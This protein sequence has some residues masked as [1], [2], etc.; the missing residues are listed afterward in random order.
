MTFSRSTLFA[1]LAACA[2][3]ASTA[4]AGDPPLSAPQKQGLK[5]AED[6]LKRGKDML[7]KANS[8]AAVDQAV[9]K[10]ENAV[11][12]LKS[13]D[14]PA[15]HSRAKEIVGECE[16]LTAA[17]ATK[18]AE[19]TK[20]AADAAVAA[21][22]K[23]YPDLAA[24]DEWYQGIRRQYAF[25]RFHDLHEQAAK[26][27]KEFQDVA[28]RH[29]ELGEKYKGFFASNNQIA[30]NVKGHAGL[31]EKELRQFFQ[32]AQNAVTKAAGDIK[33]N[34][35]R[36]EEMS[37][38]AVAEKKPAFFTGGVRQAMETSKNAVAVLKALVGEKHEK[39]LA[40][41]KDVAAA[42]AQVDTAYAALKEDVIAAQQMPED[43]YKGDDKAK[44]EQ[45]IR[46]AWAKEH[47]KDEILAIRFHMADWKRNVEETWNSGSKSWSLSDMSVLCISVIVKTND[48]IATIYPSYVNKNNLSGAVTTGVQTKGGVY[49]NEEMLVK[50]VK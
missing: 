8:A 44:L 11:A 32:G 27:M 15:E 14:V 41:E 31:A 19:V 17:A 5:L 1:A 28:K 22:P 2:F 10:F 18:R 20:S 29:K 9:A 43:K 46:E 30:A 42:Q 3:F 35:K 13:K 39:V 45:L 24:D 7:E 36:A 49:V 26:L 33:E 34:L 23:N 25:N 47:K 21:D 50:N 38:K 12:A 4:F 16:K 40:F 37:A 48:T 6:S